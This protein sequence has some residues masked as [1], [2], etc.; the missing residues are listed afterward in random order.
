MRTISLHINS[1]ALK[2]QDRWQKFSNGELKS[3]KQALGMADN[4]S[5][6]DEI[7]LPILRQIEA[8]ILL[9]GSDSR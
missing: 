9:R 3:L 8:A 1:D 6:L 4:A 7:G 2:Q 5:T